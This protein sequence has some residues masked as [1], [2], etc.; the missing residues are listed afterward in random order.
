ML[1]RVIRHL[2]LIAGCFYLT[3]LTG[4]TCYSV[5]SRFFFNKPLMWFEA[6]AKYVL[7]AMV[8]VT[9]P[10]VARTD[11]HICMRE[12]LFKMPE[13]LQ[14]VIFFLTDALCIAFYSVIAYSAV[15]MIRKN[16]SSVMIGFSQPYWWFY[17]PVVIGFVL[18]ALMYLYILIDHIRNGIP[19]PAEVEVYDLESHHLEGGKED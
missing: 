9:A 18:L 16:M 1:K 10:Y 6:Y 8:L 7:M 12:F 19:K 17:A 3:I 14:K 11:G 4:T 5:V 13:K 2:D 15:I